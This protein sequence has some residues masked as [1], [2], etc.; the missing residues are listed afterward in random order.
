[1]GVAAL[2]GPAL[3][4]ALTQL[5]GEHATGMAPASFLSM[6]LFLNAMLDPFVT[7]RS[8]GIGAGLGYAPETAPSRVRRRRT[9]PSPRRCR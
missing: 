6:G 1:M 5:S 9:T 2:T 7:G 3:G 4:N 8:D